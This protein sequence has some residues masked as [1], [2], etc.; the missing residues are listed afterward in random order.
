MPL[1]RELKESD[2]LAWSKLWDGYLLF[3]ETELSAEQSGLT[4]KRL[5]D[6][7]FNMYGLV[8]EVDGVVLGITHYSFQNSTWAPVNH[9]YLEDLFVATN[10]RGQGLGRLLIEGVKKVAIVAGSSRLYWNTD[11]TNATARKLYDSYTHD[12]GKVQYRIPLS[13]NDP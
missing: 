3:Y 1:I 11:S 7:N 13:P 2:K 4:W 9:C 8:A 12:S 5:L 6:S 10:S